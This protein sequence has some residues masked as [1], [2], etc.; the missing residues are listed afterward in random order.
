MITYC[1]TSIS[2]LY[3]TCHNIYSI[4]L[5]L[6]QLLYSLATVIINKNNNTYF[7]SLLVLSFI[8]FFDSFLTIRRMHDNKFLKFTFWICIPFEENEQKQKI[9]RT[10]IIKYIQMREWSSLTEV[11]EHKIRINFQPDDTF[12]GRKKK[13]YPVVVCLFLTIEFDWHSAWREAHQT[14]IIVFSTHNSNKNDQNFI[15]IVYYCYQ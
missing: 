8:F 12:G 1:P 3:P 7:V 14:Q 4:F 6:L 9:D 11:Y 5:F 2:S 15:W 10:K 13:R